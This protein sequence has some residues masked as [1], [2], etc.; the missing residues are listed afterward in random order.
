VQVV[1][2]GRAAVEYFER[3][4][5]QV[6]L[7]LLD[8][9]MPEMDGRECFA[10]LRQIHPAVRVLICTGHGVDGTAQRLLDTGA[11]GLLTKPYDLHQLAEAMAAA[12]QR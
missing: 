9:I 12:L 4:W 10:R 7:V 5:Q 3:N 6:D 2:D 8:L 1:G 11:R